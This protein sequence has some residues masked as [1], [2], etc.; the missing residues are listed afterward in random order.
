MPPA[1][2]I[3]ITGAS[4]GLGRELALSYAAPGIRLALAGRNKERLADTAARCVAQGATV[5]SATIDVCAADELAAWIGAI[6]DE[7][8]LDLV[9]ASAGI[10]AGRSFGRLREDPAAA[11][12]VI[13][14]N[15]VGT[16][17][18]ID[19]VV[20]RMCMRGRGHVAVV[21]S[22]GGFRGM[23]YCPGYSASKAGVHAYAEAL[24]GA[25][26]AQ[27][28]GV[29]VIAP[30]FVATP[31]NR[32]IV[33]PKPLLMT[34]ARAAG[35]IRAGLDRGAALIVFPRVLY[36]GLMLTR[37]LPRRWV[38]WAFAR[39]DVDVPEYSEAQSE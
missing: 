4:S 22:I 11:R 33:C 18:T 3:L 30:G 8:P 21:G 36:W 32:D 37:L 19:P 2:S 26:A 17:N 24:R 5:A 38:D 25:L 14:T 1:R 9:I 10:T 28:I 12:A 15:L 16:I 6:D 13:A 23:P 31:L 29:T 7:L 20:V 27:G 35:I 39:V 34:T